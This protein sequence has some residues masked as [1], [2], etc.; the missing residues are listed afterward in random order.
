MESQ[1]QELCHLCHR[2]G[3]ERP[4]VTTAVDGSRTCIMHSIVIR[5]LARSTGAR[6]A[7]A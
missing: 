7:A 3:L 6:P 2:Q 1:Q 4:A 5:R